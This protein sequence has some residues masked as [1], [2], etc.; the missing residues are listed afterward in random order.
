M[1]TI[2]FYD[3]S[4]FAEDKVYEG[5]RME[6]IFRRGGG[7]LYEKYRDKNV[8]IDGRSIGIE[9]T[10]INERRSDNVNVFAT[11][12]K[13]IQTTDYLIF[14]G[15]N[16]SEEFMGL[17]HHAF[18]CA[19]IDALPQGYEGKIYLHGCRTGSFID[20]IEPL[21]GRVYR[22]LRDVKITQEN[23][24]K[25]NKFGEHLI[26]KGTVQDIGVNIYNGKGYNA[27]EHLVNANP[28]NANL[29]EKV[30]YGSRAALERQEEKLLQKIEN[31]H[32][33]HREGVYDEERVT[34]V[35]RNRQ[36]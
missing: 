4:V 24:E 30:Y 13:P 29:T 14:V 16:G 11:E 21:A 31:R 3:E 2:I 10:Y 1:S 7:A 26:V 27:I 20:N 25:T 28:D 8:G 12:G 6:M 33:Y 23:G 22:A 34:F 19:L 15:H 5:F 36:I 32:N 17:N 35:K 9:V 18:I